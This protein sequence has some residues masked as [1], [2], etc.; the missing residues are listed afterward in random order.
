MKVTFEQIY[1]K[2]K[3][4]D[5]EIIELQ[6]LKKRIPQNKPYSLDLHLSFDKIINDLINQKL[7]LEQLEIENPPE[8]LIQNILTVDLATASA[9]RAIPKPEIEEE[10]KVI[11][12]FLRKLPKTEI[13]LHIEACISKETD[14]KSVV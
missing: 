3:N 14:R 11:L 2:I 9:I 10:D 12:D 1:K 6:N 8:D 13:H 7:E 5:K 4:I